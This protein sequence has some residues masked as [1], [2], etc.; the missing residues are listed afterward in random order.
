MIAMLIAAL[1]ST[2]GFSHDDA[3]V[4]VRDDRSSTMHGDMDD[5]R[6]ARRHL[7][8]F[9]PGYLW[10]RHDGKEY[11]VRDG[12]AIKTIEEAVQPQEELGKTQGDLGRRQA[13][14]GAPIDRRLGWGGSLG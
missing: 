9:G 10:F 12:A 11:V 14:L 2:G 3:W 7:R 5:L 6:L 8:E 4:V 13:D 1:L